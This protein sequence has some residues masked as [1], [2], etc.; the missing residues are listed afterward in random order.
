MT[1]S[2]KSKI[3][4]EKLRETEEKGIDYTTTSLFGKMVQKLCVGL[5]LRGFDV[6]DYRHNMGP[7]DQSHRY[8]NPSLGFYVICDGYERNSD[9]ANMLDVWYRLPSRKSDEEQVSI[10]V[11][12]KYFK[13]DPLEEKL[14]GYI[15][16]DTF[17]TDK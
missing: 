6:K 11:L 5:H 16:D 9:R 14:K 4:A 10:E 8:K 15:T 13:D 12:S 3:L 1:L 7:D 17:L 2:L